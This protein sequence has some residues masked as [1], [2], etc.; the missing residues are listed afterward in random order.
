MSAQMH[1]DT[2]ALAAIDEAGLVACLRALVAIPSVTGSPAESEAQ[3]WFSTRME[4]SGLATDLWPID[5]D[6]LR[7]DPEFPG[8]EAPR[9]VAWGLV[10]RW[11][12][13]SG[14]TLILNGHLD[15]V[16]PGD[17]EQWVDGD[18]FSGRL[19]AGRVHGRGSCDM[20]GGLVCCLYAIRAIRDA[21]I[22]LRGSVLLESVVGE[23]DGG[24]GTFAAL[25]RGYRGDAAIIPEPTNLAIIPAC[26]GA[27]SFRLTVRGRSAHASM[28]KQGVSAIES[29][30]PIWQAL[31]SLESRKNA[32]ADPLM[33]RFDPAYPLSIGTLKAGDWSSSVPECLVAEGRLGVALD[34]APEDARREF[35]AALR[36][37]CEKDDWLRAHPVEV[38]W[39]GGQFSSGGIAGD[40]PLVGLVRGAHHHLHGNEPDLHGAPYGSD[41]RLLTEV[42]HIP[43]LHYG[44]GEIRLAH[45]P[46]ESIDI[47]SLTAA[48]RTLDLSILRFCGTA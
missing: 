7:A 40:H 8:M 21:G 33:A 13:D 45:S 25:R 41:L 19:D 24:L 18:P 11:G 47:A 5:L 1:E 20:K 26:A 27:L 37:T 29:F 32:D 38:E 17:P 39:F 31:Q 34:E 10:G 44:P 48:T 22:T 23:E 43:A 2:A 6:A 46:D 28:R 3:H 42:G 16:P 9:D 35:E 14:P 12:N 30:W 4:E 15:V 36:T